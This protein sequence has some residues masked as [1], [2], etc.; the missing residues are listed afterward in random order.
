MDIKFNVDT[1]TLVNSK[2]SKEY[3]QEFG[4]NK[5]LII[6]HYQD[7]S[8]SLP[9]EA[10]MHD[11]ASVQGI[12]EFI[13]SEENYLELYRE[14]KIDFKTTIDM[15]SPENQDEFECLIAF[16]RHEEGSELG[17]KQSY[18]ELD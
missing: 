16:A 7:G 8:S 12:A 18:Y 1:L 17:L 2:Y 6:Y 4:K 5:N 11:F 13:L 14:G 15:G 10:S 9:E 3:T